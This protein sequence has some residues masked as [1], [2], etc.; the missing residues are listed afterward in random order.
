MT[1]VWRGKGGFTTRK[2]RVCG[3]RT[4]DVNEIPDIYGDDM[5]Y[6]S[7]GIFLSVSTHP[8]HSRRSILGS[9]RWAGTPVSFM[10][11]TR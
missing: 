7:G 8:P 6:S 1:G 3:T 2:L 11:R 4:L 10:K 9:R 5:H